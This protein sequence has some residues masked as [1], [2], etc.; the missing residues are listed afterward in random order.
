M[1]FMYLYSQINVISSTIKR[2]INITLEYRQTL[3]FNEFARLTD[4]LFSFLLI[5]K[6]LKTYKTRSVIIIYKYMQ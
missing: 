2:I 1:I 3:F 4:A 6:I 5:K